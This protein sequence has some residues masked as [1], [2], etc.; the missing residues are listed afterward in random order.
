VV[1]L[2]HPVDPVVH[3]LDPVSHAYQAQTAIVD[4]VGVLSWMFARVTK[5][6]VVSLLALLSSAALVAIAGGVLVA[7]YG[8][9]RTAAEAVA[10][11]LLF[12][13]L[14]F[15]IE[16]TFA[17]LPWRL[18]GPL[19]VI[20]MAATAVTIG[21][22]RRFAPPLLG[23]LALGAILAMTA[24]ILSAT[25]YEA[26]DRRGRSMEVA[27]EEVVALQRLSPSLVIFHSSTFPREYW[28]R[29]FHPPPAELPAVALGWN[30]QNPQVQRFLT[31]TGRQPLLR[32]LCTAPSILVV[33]ESRTLDVVTRYLS[34]HFDTSVR[35]TQVYAG[36]F[37]AWRCSTHNHLQSEIP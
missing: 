3:G 10:V 24:P 9:R 14:C 7:A 29:P 18:L 19:Q 2:E 35:W 20:F 32:A 5:A 23:V 16:V 4:R 13:A 1:E 33:A 30:N 21:A 11:L 22:S 36:S 34:E 17:K 27:N 37:P 12:C 6:P 25:A 15:A 8:T 31:D 26:A 28:W